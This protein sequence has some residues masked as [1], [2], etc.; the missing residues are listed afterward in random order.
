MNTSHRATLP[1]LPAGQHVALDGRAVDF[2]EAVLQEIVDSYDPKLHE[3]PLVIG[4]PKLNGPAYGWAK[5]VELRAGMLFAEPHQ[6]VPEFAEAANRKM[7]K[8]RSA[9]VYLPDSP[10]NPTPGKHY[11]RHIGFLGAMPPAIK[12]IPDTSLEFAEE[13]GALALEF[14]E[15]PYAFTAMADILRRLRDFFVE[16]EGAEQADLII[17]Q[18]QIKSIEESA[19]NSDER[20]VAFSESEQP[21]S[22]APTPEG[23]EGAAASAAAAPEPGNTDPSAADAG[24]VSTQEPAMADDDRETQLAERER[25]VAEGEA[26]IAAAQAQEKE[27]EAAEFAEGLV[28]S[29]QL[30]PRQKARVVS[31]LLNLPAD[32]PLEFAEGEQTISEPADKVLRALLSDLPKQVDFSEKSGGGDIVDDQDANAIAAR[33]TAYQSEQRQAGNNISISQAVNHVTKGA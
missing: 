15:P 25:K 1:I 20:A 26:R 16:R 9:S 23:D 6:V 10:G 19:R 33:A 32:T 22:E 18:W 14:A 4:H 8:K 24:A 5:S 28:A 27:S 21:T 31:L 13:D 11:L 17:P 3:A 30:L 2:T 12:G 29:G 7:Y